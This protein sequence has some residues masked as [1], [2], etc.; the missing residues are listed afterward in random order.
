MQFVL[1]VSVYVSLCFQETVYQNPPDVQ[2]KK[3][4]RLTTGGHLFI[5]IGVCR[6]VR[7]TAQT[8][9]YH[10]DATV[11]HKIKRISPKC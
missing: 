8:S 5:Y 7:K 6:V 10:I 9:L 11:Q 3:T 4:R 2:G 1:T